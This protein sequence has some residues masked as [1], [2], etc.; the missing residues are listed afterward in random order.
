[1]NMTNVN[2]FTKLY[3]LIMQTRTWSMQWSLT[4]MWELLITDNKTT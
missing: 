1:M 2:A 4:E 3:M